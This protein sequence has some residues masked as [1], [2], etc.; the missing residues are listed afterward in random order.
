MKFWEGHS[1]PLSSLN[2]VQISHEIGS[3]GKIFKL[4]EEDI[5]RRLEQLEE[6]TKGSLIWT[7]QAGLKVLLRTKE[8]LTNPDEFSQELLAKSFGVEHE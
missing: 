4:S 1:V 3:P 7:E 2:F 5:V 6:M 8:A